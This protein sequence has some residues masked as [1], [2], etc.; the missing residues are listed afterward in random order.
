MS[1]IMEQP[2]P[3]KPSRRR[4]LWPPLV[5]IAGMAAFYW[6]SQAGSK[7]LEGWGDNLGQAL[8]K[9]GSSG[10]PVLVYFSAPG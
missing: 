3:P 8:A 10:Q 7:P 6:L 9:A 4:S 1:D 2:K 5:L